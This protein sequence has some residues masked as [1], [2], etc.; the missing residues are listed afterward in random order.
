MSATIKVRSTQDSETDAT[1]QS[2]THTELSSPPSEND[3]SV[4]VAALHSRS[5]RNNAL[6][7]TYDTDTD[8]D[9]SRINWREDEVLRLESMR[10]AGFLP[11]SYEEDDEYPSSLDYWPLLQLCVVSAIVVCILKILRD[12]RR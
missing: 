11:S 12:C 4:E 7:E 2:T 3:P 8:A 9:A 1:L 5:N 10:E 6:D